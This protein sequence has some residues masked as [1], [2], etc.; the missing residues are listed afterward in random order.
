MGTRK[1]PKE[2]GYEKIPV[3]VLLVRDAPFMEHRG[4]GR[5][6]AHSGHSAFFNRENG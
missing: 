4:Q 1:Y 3:N 2:G 5:D 6:K